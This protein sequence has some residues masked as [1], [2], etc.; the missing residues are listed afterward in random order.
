M[1]DLGKEQSRSKRGAEERKWER[2][3]FSGKLR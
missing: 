2:E 3:Q 1:S